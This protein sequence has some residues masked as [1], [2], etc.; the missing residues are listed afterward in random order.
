MLFSSRERDN[1]TFEALTLLQCKNAQSTL[2][3]FSSKQ[4]GKLF[5]KDFL[6]SNT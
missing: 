2:D 6:D 3:C 5:D 4:H 1:K